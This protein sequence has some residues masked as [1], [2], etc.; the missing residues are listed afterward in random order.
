MCSAIWSTAA[1]GS[2]G[3]SRRGGS[4]I[5]L[6]CVISLR[7]HPSHPSLLLQVEYKS[8]P[9]HPP[10]QPH[11]TPPADPRTGTS[12]WLYEEFIPIEYRAQLSAGPKRKI[13]F[14]FRS[15]HGAGGTV[16]SHFTAS[17]GRPMP[18]IPNARELE[19]E[20]LLKS[21]GNVTKV[22]T[23]NGGAGRTVTTTSAGPP[24]A[25]AVGISGPLYV[26]GKDG[27]SGADAYPSSSV[28]S[29]STRHTK[30]DVLP[31]TPGVTELASSP[32]GPGTPT[33]T[34]MP[35]HGPAKRSRFPLPTMPSPSLRRRGP[36]AE[37]D[38]TLE[39]ETRT[40]WD[41]GRSAHSEEE[42]ASERGKTKKS[43]KRESQDDAWVDILVGSQSRRMD[44]QAAVMMMR[45]PGTAEE[46]GVEEAGAVKHKKRVG[47]VG[48]FGE[49]DRVQ[50]EVRKALREA[51]PEP[52]DV[53]EYE[54]SS[55]SHYS[56]K[57]SAAAAA[58][59][60]QRTSE[61]DD[62]DDD[63]DDEPED[64]QLYGPPERGG[65][66]RVD[67][68][69][70]DSADFEPM[71]HMRALSERGGGLG[72][73]SPS[74]SPSP[75]PKLPA[76][77]GVGSLIDMYRKKEEEAAGSVPA[78]PSKIPVASKP[79]PALPSHL[80]VAP[81]APP[82]APSGPPRPPSQEVLIDDDAS[83]VVPSE[84]DDQ[85]LEEYLKRHVKISSSTPRYVHGAPLHNVV[86]IEEDED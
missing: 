73:V 70:V 21:A 4:V 84:M 16:A 86:E 7:P 11:S 68:A 60:R 81:S 79:T 13:L 28:G 45:R 12:L 71:P 62:A 64:E 63:D 23:L 75:L 42:E 51:G 24:A 26:A 10:R 83:S 55:A 48:S 38:A 44:G 61:E 15:G 18:R 3:A 47:V 49:A 1:V 43:K 77:A 69:S 14:P 17:F 20:G 59:R 58:G 52:L 30:E 37:Y 22:I 31:P 65:H 8:I 27:T 54:A 39:F 85:E 76:K 82:V 46:R 56:E 78:G 67:H 36:P 40:M 19:F 29:S 9:Q 2:T 72:D 34:Q 35:T 33:Q 32:S 80:V 57:T 6:W 25:G 74:P 53:F 41:D 66:A 50:E 5:G